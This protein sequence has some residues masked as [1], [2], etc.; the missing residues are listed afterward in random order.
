ML[1]ATI[2]FRVIPEVRR[3]EWRAIGFL[4]GHRELNASDVLDGLRQNQRLDLLSSIGRWLDGAYGPKTRFHGFP[5][6]PDYDTCFVFKVRDNRFYGYLCHPLPKGKPA[7]QLCVLCIHTT[8]NEF[9]TD[10]SELERVK[11]W[12]LSNEAQMAISLVYP[13][14][15]PDERR[16]RKSWKM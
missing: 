14:K 11:R 5:N 10:R 2:T 3:S 8:K 4:E 7:F 12:S 15:G 9:E 13:D 6:D 1:P 16:G